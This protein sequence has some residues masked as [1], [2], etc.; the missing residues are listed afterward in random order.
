LNLISDEPCRFGPERVVLF[1]SHACGCPEP[2]SDVDLL[3]VFRGHADAADHALEIR[4][5]VHCPF[6][7]DLLVRSEAELRCRYEIEDW[8]IREIVDKGKVLY[9]PRPN[10]KDGVA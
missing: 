7:I 4:K 8:F 2:G 1:G 10:P 3:V 5:Q 9:I 6:P